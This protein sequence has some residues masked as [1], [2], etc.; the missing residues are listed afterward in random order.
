MMGGEE[1][2]PDVKELDM[3][4]NVSIGDRVIIQVKKSST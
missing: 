4:K 2:A 3:S 1:V